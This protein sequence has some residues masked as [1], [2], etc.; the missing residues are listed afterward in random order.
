MGILLTIVL[1]PVR[2]FV[3]F[4]G[5]AIATA[6]AGREGVMNHPVVVTMFALGAVYVAIAYLVARMFVAF[7]DAALGHSGSIVEAFTRT[8]DNMGR[9]LI[10]TVLIQIGALAV[11]LFVGLGT[12]IVV[13]TL[14]QPASL[15]ALTFAMVGASV[16]Y[17]PVF[18]FNL[19]VGITM[20]SVAYREIVGLPPD[21]AAALANEAA[22]A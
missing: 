11:S 15:K 9:L 5:V 17:F 21:A 18:I 14:V 13:N 1:L 22:P 16:I 4:G 6:I 8:D 3:F 7:P 12:T 19:M 2:F 10:Y 20:L